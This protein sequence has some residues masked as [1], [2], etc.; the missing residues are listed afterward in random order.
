MVMTVGGHAAQAV[1]ERRAVMPGGFRA[2]GVAAG[3]KASGRPDVAL[4]A[5]SITSAG[6]RR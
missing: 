3:I 6:R 2:A 5:S 1:V 4:I